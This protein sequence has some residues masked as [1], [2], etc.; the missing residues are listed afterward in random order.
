MLQCL[1]FEKGKETKLIKKKLIAI[2]MSAVMIFSVAS[3]TFETTVFAKKATSAKN[4]T[5]ITMNVGKTKNIK[6]KK[7]TTKVKWKVVKGKKVVKI[8]KTSG[9]YKNKVKI[10]AVKSGKAVLRAKV[11]KKTYTYNI[12]V[13]KTTKN[14]QQQTTNNTTANETNVVTGKY[15]IN[16]QYCY[17][18]NKKLYG[19]LYMPE[20][21][22][23]A[24]LP[25]IIFSHGFCDTYARFAELQKKLAE[26]GII[27]YAFDFYGGSPYTK[28]GGK[29][30][31][32]SVITEKEELEA[33]EKMIKGMK[34][35][36]Q[37]NLYLAGHSQGGHVTTL[38]SYDLASEIKG[39]FLFAPAF[40]MND[41]A[42][43]TF[44]GGESTV[45]ETVPINAVVTT[46]K[47]YWTELLKY[48][49]FTKMTF[50]KSVL[51]FHGTKDTDV[52]VSYS[53]K[54]V[55]TFKN[56]KLTELQGE[57]HMLANSWD[58]IYEGIVAEVF[59]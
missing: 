11:G 47:T 4:I 43:A 16:D 50:D 39:L 34:N 23:E 20:I 13:N 57:D 53:Q 24:K 8:K 56:A 6:V 49:I 2:T 30:T 45:P 42:K 54:A 15:T 9:K 41:V 17:V 32:M 28:S 18:G 10:K 14:N 48:D 33:V 58:K 19:K 51:I 25:T 40:Q 12:T 1:L 38:A 46:G 35:V 3:A 31:E 29:M 44:P 21:N 52:D 27:S 59:K 26:K 37:S 36:D 22:G 7:A 55:S 5:K